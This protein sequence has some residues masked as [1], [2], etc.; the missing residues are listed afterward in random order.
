[1]GVGQTVRRAG[2]RLKSLL[3]SLTSWLKG[4]FAGLR[5]KAPKLGASKEGASRE[6]SSKAGE[7]SKGFAWLSMR[8]ALILIAGI[9]VYYIGGA[10]LLQKI[11]NNIDFRPEATLK[12]DQSAAVAMSIALI[13]R[14]VKKNGWTA[15]DP[16]FKP[17]AI[18]DN[19]PNYQKGMIA[20]IARFSFELTDQLG[21]T[22]G[23]S[24]ADDDLQEAAGL[25]QY[26]GDKWLWG[27]GGNIVPTATA[28]QQY[29]RAATALRSYNQRLSEGNAVFERRSDNLLAT[30]DRIALDLGSS[31]AVIDTHVSEEGGWP[32]H[33]KADDVYYTVKGQLYGYYMI[34]TALG[35]DFS[36]VIKERGVE[37]P[38][39]QMLR[40]MEIAA[41]LE[42]GVIL[43]GKADAQFVPCNLCGQGFYL[44]R[45]R[46]Q[47]REITNILLK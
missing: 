38:Y 7:G 17:T 30:L 35:D 2:L 23:S 14:E 31:S 11:D 22:R 28:E 12:A 39:A 27:S 20:A 24:Q 15:N 10:L 19:M 21:R 33:R 18:L 29:K 32:I 25:L 42:P 5:K 45:A 16:F 46:T 4:V 37:K 1:M 8:A 6:G 40:S 13:D 26:P 44:L 36:D 34:L 3:A 47:L 9:A 43:N 41:T